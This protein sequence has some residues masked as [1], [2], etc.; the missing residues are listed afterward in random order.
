MHGLFLNV[1][2]LMLQLWAGT[3]PTPQEGVPACAATK[4][5]TNAWQSM[6]QDL[7]GAARGIP[8]AFGGTV[9][10][11][12]KYHLSLKA[13]E[14]QEWVL[15]Y[16]MP[17]LQGRLSDELLHHWSLLVRATQLSLQVDG[18]TQVDLVEIR[19]CF[20]DFVEGYERYTSRS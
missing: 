19:R 16:S 14:M 13:S 9:R 12:A 15:L 10:D 1:S 8:S 5:A 17:L 11:I 3:L 18:I 2:K 7:G 20:A 6:G 4:M